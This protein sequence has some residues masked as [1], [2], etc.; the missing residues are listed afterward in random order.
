MSGVTNTSRTSADGAPGTASPPAGMTRRDF[1]VVSGKTMFAAASAGSL[2]SACGGSGGSSSTSLVMGYP[3]VPSQV[4]PSTFSGVDNQLAMGNVYATPMQFAQKDIGN[5]YPEVPVKDPQAK[6]WLA[7]SLEPNADLKKFRLTLRDDIKSFRGN[8]LS[9]EDVRWTVER[10]NAIAGNGQIIVQ[11]AGLRR[12]GNVKVID[13]QTI[14]FLL[15]APS[16]LLPQ[17]LQNQYGFGIVD[18][19]EAKKHVTAKD[20]YANEWL[21]RNGAGFGP[22]HLTKY[23][24]QRLEFTPNPG[25]KIESLAYR[26][27]R[28]LAVPEPSN[29]FNLIKAGDIQIITEL[30][31]NQLKNI[32]G[33]S[34]IKTYSTNTRAQA[35]QMFFNLAVPELKDPRVR[36]ALTYAIP[37][38]GILDAVYRGTATAWET[39]LGGSEYRGADKALNPF[40]EDP[41]RAM[42]LLSAAGAERLNV[43]LN[44]DTSSFWQRPAAIQLQTAWRAIGVEA[45][46]EGLA[47][48]VWG[49]RLGKKE[50][51]IFMVALNW[52]I[53]D[54]FYV[55]NLLY[56]SDSGINFA[57]YKKPRADELIDTGIEEPDAAK[58]DGLARQF[59]ELFYEDLPSAGLAV[60]DA[61]T[62]LDSDVE[63]YT[64]KIN[65]MA[66]W[67]ELKPA[68]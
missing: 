60:R 67:A 23:T 47:P 52:L 24:P 34:G 11:V 50:M 18:S 35:D 51:P 6:P 57:G 3:S 2:L 56:R 15:D 9:A 65:G 66:Y 30:E 41:E 1:V 45:E 33:T 22:Y 31:P 42:E 61:V 7:A 62:A 26:E 58:R 46:L 14:D 13:D 43:K 39:P 25:Y 68:A 63:G 21:Q 55:M 49:E 32:E 20:K 8:P 44:F 4:D 16:R 17:L 29:R 36:A 48:S 10:N 37:S 53:P 64:A 59:Q 54:F 38:R 40:N 28:W 5:G 12:P 27:V 19:V